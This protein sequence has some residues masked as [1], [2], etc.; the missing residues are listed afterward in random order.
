MKIALWSVFYNQV[1]F[2]QAPQKQNFFFIAF[3]KLLTYQ[4]MIT[5]PIVLCQLKYLGGI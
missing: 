4:L 5:F 2:E 1:L 3:G